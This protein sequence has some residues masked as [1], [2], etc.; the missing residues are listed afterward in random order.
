M[1]ELIS[2]HAVLKELPN[3]LWGKEYD[4]ALA[5]AIIESVPTIDAVPVVRCKDCKHR[6][7]DKGGHGHG[8]ELLFPDDGVCPGQCDDPWYSWLP[9]DNWFCANG[10]RSKKD[11]RRQT[12]QSY[13]GIHSYGV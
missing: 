10:E 2:R 13:A 11:E 1:N 6:P 9:D 3:A 7:I 4:E 5:K 12:Q 8:N